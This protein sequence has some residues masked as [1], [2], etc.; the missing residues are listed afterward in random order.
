MGGMCTVLKS[1][2]Y[3]HAITLH[4]LQRGDKVK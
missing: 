1:E 2:T 4:T 3:T